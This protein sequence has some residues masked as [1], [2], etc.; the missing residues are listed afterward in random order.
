M[1][2]ANEKN[3]EENSENEKMKKSVER[4]EGGG[5][6]EKK[7]HINGR[8]IGEMKTRKPRTSA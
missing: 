2:L 3:K 8:M 5:E 7:Q 6:C 4:N 1:A